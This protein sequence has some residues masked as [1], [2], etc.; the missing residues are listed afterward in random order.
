MRRGVHSLILAS[1]AGACFVAPPRLTRNRAPILLLPTRHDAQRVIGQRSLERH[2]VGRRR[3]EP[4][5]SNKPSPVL[6]A[7]N[8]GA[9]LADREAA[10]QLRPGQNLENAGSK[11]ADFPVS[12]AVL[13][14]P[15]WWFRA[16]F[17]RGVAP[18]SS[19]PSIP[20]KFPLAQW[21][22]PK[23]LT[24]RAASVASKNYPPCQGRRT[25]SVQPRL[26][27]MGAGISS[28]HSG[29][30]LRAPSRCAQH[31]GPCY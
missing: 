14:K 7:R 28:N 23:H 9:G 8:G 5:N 17:S 2:R 19:D 26:R 20:P 27:K 10:S 25:F 29:N 6:P 22:R 21:Q 15:R 31:V 3:A 1:A 24:K 12:H 30:E 16:S 4:R 13:V 18:R 11:A